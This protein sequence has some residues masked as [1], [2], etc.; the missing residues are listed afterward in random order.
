MDIGYSKKKLGRRVK[1][2]R[3][4]L[5]LSGQELADRIGISPGYICDIEK[6]RCHPSAV[7]TASLALTLGMP[8]D[9]LITGRKNPFKGHLS[10][11]QMAVISDFA[12]V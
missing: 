12:E 4:L 3:T 11:E 5:E 9:F 8:I 6:G 10:T 1:M 7:I 2:A